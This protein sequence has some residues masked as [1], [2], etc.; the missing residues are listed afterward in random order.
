MSS[1]SNL[2]R[3]SPGKERRSIKGTACSRVGGGEVAFSHNMTRIL[4]NPVVSVPEWSKGLVSSEF[5]ASSLMPGY[6]NGFGRVG[7][8]PTAD[9]FFVSLS[10]LHDMD[11]ASCSQTT[12]L[13]QE[14]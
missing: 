8:N 14:P 5:R 10:V 12:W 3:T 4:F 6:S 1:T 2:W 13:H 9:N 7:S 11:A